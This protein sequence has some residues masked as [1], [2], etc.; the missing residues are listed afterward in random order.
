MSVLKDSNERP[1]APPNKQW[2]CSRCTYMNNKDV[3]CCEMCLI[4]RDHET[5]TT[6]DDSEP[7]EPGLGQWQCQQCTL[8][9]DIT[10]RYCAL[11]S[12]EL[13][14]DNL[15]PSECMEIVTHAQAV[16]TVV[17]AVSTNGLVN[18]DKMREIFR[19]ESCN[20]KEDEARNSNANAIDTTHCNI[21]SCT[22][23]SALCAIMSLYQEL[24]STGLEEWVTMKEL[25][26][27][28][29][30][31]LERHR[32]D[33]D[34]ISTQIIEACGNCKLHKCLR[35]KRAFRN[36]MKD[37]EAIRKKLNII[38]DDDDVTD[39]NKQR[40]LDRIH[41][42]FCHSY[43]IGHRI[44][45]NDM[46]STTTTTE[47]NPNDAVNEQNNDNDSD[48]IKQQKEKP[49]TVLTEE[50]KQDTT[51]IQSKR[52]SY[53]HIEGLYRIQTQNNRFNLA[54]NARIM[55]DNGIRYFYWEYYKKAEKINDPVVTYGTAGRVKRT[56]DQYANEGYV[57]KD[58]YIEAKYPNL[59]TE[60]LCR[61]QVDLYVWSATE[62][63][64]HEHLN[65]EKGKRIASPSTHYDE[66]RPG[67]LN[68]GHL[69][70][71]MLY[72]NLDVLQYEFSKTFRRLPNE[73]D[74]NLK[75][76]A[77]NFANMG[78]LLREFVECFGTREDKDHHFMDEVMYRGI[79]NKTEFTTIV[80]RIKGTFSATTEWAVAVNFMQNTGMIVEFQI[81][82]KHIIGNRMLLTRG[83]SYYAFVDC[84]WLSNFPSEAER[85]FIGGYSRFF[86]N[87]IQTPSETYALHISAMRHILI[88]IDFADLYLTGNK[89]NYHSA[90]ANIAHMML[91]N[92]LSKHFDTHPSWK[93][94]PQYIDDLFHNFCQNLKRFHFKLPTGFTIQDKT[95]LRVYSLLKKTFGFNSGTI[96]LDTLFTVLPRVEEIHMSH[97]YMSEFGM[98][99]IGL[100]KQDAFWRAVVRAIQT[101]QYLKRIEIEI[102]IENRQK[103][104][105]IMTPVVQ[106]YNGAIA[107]RGWD[108]DLGTRK[109]KTTGEIPFLVI[110]K[111]MTLY[112]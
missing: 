70:A 36:V 18:S 95:M 66:Y 2:K 34:F 104:A 83:T 51:H 57:L 106:Q 25:L 54:D 47:V 94:I 23:V 17:D 1:Y 91:S 11:C 112:I 89:L 81:G 30:H 56:D 31:L 50:K 26:D 43:H 109:G 68:S 108:V 28:F 96:Q 4:Q 74:E 9:N 69:T 59:K 107:S 67:D 71:M 80:P 37:N 8:W 90:V 105:S 93:D 24:G 19:I 20:E 87:S 5:S 63:Q 27:I 52:E 21:E 85:F 98:P 38:H 41:C 77:T 40:L 79:T 48:A 76:R 35:M 42:Y 72:C 84:A 53:A 75:K 78:R 33:Y 58:W 6:A 14:L 61:I 12:W 46:T 64:A 111:S 97:N 7:K 15:D 32:N 88:L 73:S 82:Y 16:H 65:T 13:E 44:P 60:M 102:L 55:Y 10:T 92:E 99:N 39:E 49:E 22:C 62:Q 103:V 29:H 86:I 100:L 110:S 101:S 45:K 3:L